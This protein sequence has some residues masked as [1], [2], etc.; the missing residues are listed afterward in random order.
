MTAAAAAP[1]RLGVLD[2][3]PL[4]QGSDAVAALRGSVEL[5]RAADRLGFARYWVA[6]HHDPQRYAGPSPE[7]LVGPIGLVTSRIRVGS[8]GVMLPHYSPRKVAESFAVLAGLLGDRVDLAVGRAAG[9]DD[10]ALIHALQRDRRTPAPDDFAE[11]LDE[12]LCYLDG[13]PPPDERFARLPPL[14]AGAEPWLLGSSPASA[15]LAARRG[16]PYAY[17]EFINPHDGAEAAELYR[18]V[19]RRS[20][21]LAAPRVAICVSAVCAAT[22]AE[23]LRL[24]ASARLAARLRR[25]GRLVALPPPDEAL[26]ELRARDPEAAHR[27]GHTIAGCPERVRAGIEQRARRCGAEEALV[28]TVTHDL[29]DRR[30]SYELLAGAF[31]LAAPDAPR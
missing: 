24:A 4:S 2:Q 14:P 20:A 15:V 5:A 7:V 30:R 17:G 23:A 16:L 12:L 9:T 27:P 22:D 31:G 25:A 18:R 28:V 29:D 3:S 13:R 8:G 10:P 21:R 19:F 11:Q 6:E 1:L 26:R